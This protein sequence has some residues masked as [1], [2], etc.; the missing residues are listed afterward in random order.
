ML[1]LTPIVWTVR[2]TAANSGAGDET[3]V[4]TASLGVVTA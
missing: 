3:Y 2:C 1:T 4:L